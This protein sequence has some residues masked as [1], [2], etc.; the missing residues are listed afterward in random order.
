MPH[1]TEAHL[2]KYVVTQ[3][4]VGF[5][6]IFAYP[7]TILTLVEHHLQVLLKHTNK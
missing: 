1:A 7:Y 2:L 6:L 3:I 4:T 5:G